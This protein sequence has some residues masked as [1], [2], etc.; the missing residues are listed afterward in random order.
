M[1]V[2]L[3]FVSYGVVFISAVLTEGEEPDP[4][5]WANLF[6]CDASSE[7]NDEGHAPFSSGTK[8]ATKMSVAKRRNLT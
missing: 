2:R 8:S 1:Q 3:H 6:Q 7:H 5:K 4:D